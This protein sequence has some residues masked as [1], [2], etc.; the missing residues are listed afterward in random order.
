MFNEELLHELNVR[1]DMYVAKDR[2]GNWINHDRPRI[3]M[4]RSIDKFI[5]GFHRT[6]SMVLF[7]DAPYK[8]YSNWSFF[9]TIADAFRRVRYFHCDGTKV[10]PINEETVARTIKQVYDSF[11]EEYLEDCKRRAAERWTHGSAIPEELLEMEWL[12]LQSRGLLA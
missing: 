2:Q 7:I 1:A 6:G 3:A 9:S 12:E 11:P 5:V 10:E 4:C 8:Q